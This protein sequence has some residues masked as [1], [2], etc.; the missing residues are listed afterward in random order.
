[1]R[2]WRTI[3]VSAWT[4]GL[5]AALFVRVALG[6]APPT[7]N[8]SSAATD[9]QTVEEVDHCLDP[10]SSLDQ[11][12]KQCTAAIEWMATTR[13][14]SN[15]E[16]YA[17]V[18]ALFYKLRGSA[19][20]QKRQYDLAI[21]DFTEAI[22]LRPTDSDAYYDRGKLYDDKRDYGHAIEDFTKAFF[23]ASVKKSA[24]AATQIGHVYIETR[25][26][27]QAMHWFHVAADKGDNDAM[28]MIGGIYASRILPDCD[29]ALVWIKKAIAGGNELAKQD[30]RS[31]FDGR[32][33][34]QK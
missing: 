16:S 15:K 25:D 6:Q 13:S 2:D 1:M 24:S 28:Y 9:A 23:S 11:T 21:D 27:G 14:T 5:I 22:H 34:W 7:S 3:I 26:Y 19:Y 31:G 4:A 32:C 30:L 17:G 29:S 18:M 10:Y 33:H 12:I 8:P 20:N